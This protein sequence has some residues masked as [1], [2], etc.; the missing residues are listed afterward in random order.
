LELAVF[1]KPTKPDQT[2]FSRFRRFLNP[3]SRAR[4]VDAL[5]FTLG[6]NRYGFH[7]RHTGTSYAKLVFFHPEGF[8][9]HVVHS[10]AP[11]SQN[12]DA[13][14]FKLRWDRYGFHKKQ[15]GTCY[16]ELVVLHPVESVGHALHSSVSRVRNVNTLFFML[17]WDRYK[18]HKKHIGT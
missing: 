7:K 3:W 11:M 4:N 17:G 2:S 9:D 10:G 6:W 12:I 5:F 13:L 14:F 8:A 18:I 1:R 16:A 15:T